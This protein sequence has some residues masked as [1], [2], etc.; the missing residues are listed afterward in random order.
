[1]PDRTAEARRILDRY[2]VEVVERFDLCPWA[3]G[4]RAGGEVAIAVLFGAPSLDAWVAAA[5]ELLA[6][7]ATRV[8]MIVAPE[9]AIAPRAFHELRN[10]V[11][12]RVPAVGVAE[13]HPDASLDLGT[14]A[15]LVPY[16]RRSPDPL[17]QLV[18]LAI[19]DSV[20]GPS[21]TAS[22]MW[23][24]GALAELAPSPRADIGDRIAA[25]NHA[26]VTASHA[27]ID[28]ALADI[29]ADRRAAYARAGIAAAG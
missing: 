7:P 12:R 24:A 2:L 4:A 22:R 13:F 26:T 3:R 11:A 17:L 29:A 19:L 9:L 5:S 20:R 23:Q 27:A 14:P 21:P 18:P 15:R 28:A 1:M 25:A 6:R 16:L 8:A 10:E